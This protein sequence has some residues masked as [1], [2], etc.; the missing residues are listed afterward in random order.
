MCPI[1]PA[2]IGFTACVHPADLKIRGQATADESGLLILL[3]KLKQRV[4]FFLHEDW[5]ARYE[6]ACPLSV[7]DANV[8]SWPL[9][10]A[11]RLAPLSTQRS[12]TPGTSRHLLLRASRPGVGG[13]LDAATAHL[14]VDKGFR[15]GQAG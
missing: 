8:C 5:V 12:P 6:L 2:Q 3:L 9:L 13:D 7:N 15:A 11:K 14:L 4:S 10:A 1:L